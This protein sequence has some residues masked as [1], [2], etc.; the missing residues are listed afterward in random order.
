MVQE[1]IRA[2][3]QQKSLPKIS[4]LDAIEILAA[5][6]SMVSETTIVNCF[7]KAGL[8][9]ENQDKAA[10]DEDDPFKDLVRELTKL[11]CKIEIKKFLQPTQVDRN[12]LT[13]TTKS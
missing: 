11:T 8:S 4:I 1:Y 9:S 7:A 5:L 6:W 13:A 2:I 3:D 12:L 10:S